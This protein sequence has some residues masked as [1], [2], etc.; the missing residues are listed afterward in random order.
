MARCPPNDGVVRDWQPTDFPSYVQELAQKHGMRFIDLTPALVA[1]AQATGS[2]LYNT[3]YDCHLNR[4][5]SEVVAATLIEALR[6]ELSS[7]PS[8][9]NGD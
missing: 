4:R 2:L 5:G 6:G 9:P 7:A 1:E 8:T 3:M